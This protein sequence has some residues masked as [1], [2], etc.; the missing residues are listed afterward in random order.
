MKGIPQH[1]HVI[2]FWSCQHHTESQ[3][4]STMH[5]Y[6]IVTYLQDFESGSFTYFPFQSLHVIKLNFHSAM[7]VVHNTMK[8]FIQR[9]HSCIY[10]C[11]LLGTVCA[12]LSQQDLFHRVAYDHIHV[13]ALQPRARGV[14]WHSVNS[15]SPSKSLS[16]LI[17]RTEDWHTQATLLQVAKCFVQEHCSYDKINRMYTML[18]FTIY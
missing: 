17:P 7:R 6:R 14:Q 2:V 11:S 15:A 5:K 10:M 18:F 16:G 12:S 8:Q 1:I 3:P 13:F 4:P 9:W